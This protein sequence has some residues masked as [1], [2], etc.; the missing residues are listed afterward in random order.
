MSVASDILEDAKRLT[1]VYIAGMKAV[2][3]P[4]PA[5]VFV[6]LQNATVLG[7]LTVEQKAIDEAHSMMN[8]L[9]GAWE[10]VVPYRY[11]RSG[12]VTIEISAQ[13]VR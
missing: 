9:G 3:Q 10:T 5:H 7:V 6:L 2:Q 12:I 11:W 8:S 4:I 1:D 13:D